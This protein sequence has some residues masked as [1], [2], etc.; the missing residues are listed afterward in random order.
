LAKSGEA[1]EKMMSTPA[2]FGHKKRDKTGH[3]DPSEERLNQRD[4]KSQD[5]S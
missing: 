4:V 1:H 2:F 5:S 3:K